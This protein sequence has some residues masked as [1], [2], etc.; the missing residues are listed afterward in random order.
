[1]T[2]HRMKV[3]L[4]IALFLTIGLSTAHADSILNLTSNNLGISGSVGTIAIS[5][6]GQ[7]S[8]GVHHNES[9]LLPQAAGW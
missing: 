3:C 2:A 4:V 1:M 6:T 7:S 9:R 8:H 5:D